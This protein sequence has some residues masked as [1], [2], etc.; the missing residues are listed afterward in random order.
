MYSFT[1]FVT[2]EGKAKDAKEAVNKLNSYVPKKN[3]PLPDYGAKLGD[4]FS[5]LPDSGKYLTWFDFNDS[6]VF[7]AEETAKSIV[8]KSGIKYS[9]I[10]VEGIP[11][12]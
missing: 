7:K 6:N 10:S 2:I 1:A 12:E 8:S 5:K 4:D 3:Q 11:E 9:D